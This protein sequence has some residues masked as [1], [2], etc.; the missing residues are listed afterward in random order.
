ELAGRSA[1]Y[2]TNIAAGKTVVAQAEL[3]SRHLRALAT[4][5]LLQHIRFASP[6]EP[7]IL[8]PPRARP[9]MSW[10]R[11]LT[12]LSKLEPFMALTCNGGVKAHSCAVHPACGGG[13]GGGGH[14]SLCPPYDLLTKCRSGRIPRRCWPESTW[15]RRCPG[16][17][18][19]DCRS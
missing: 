7:P 2:T 5:L 9:K 14:A 13:A 10:P 18:L 6:S 16:C 11:P 12:R 17:P 15:P 19:R 3:R 4:Q 8:T 1:I